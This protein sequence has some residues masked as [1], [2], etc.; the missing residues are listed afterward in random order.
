MPRLK[1]GGGAGRAHTGGPVWNMKTDPDCCPVAR[2]AAEHV[3]AFYEELDRRLDALLSVHPG[4]SCRECG[5]CCIFLPGVPVLYATVL[6]HAYLAP[7]L[8][9]PRAGL[10]EGACPCL[11]LDTR[12]CTARGR[13]PVVCRMHFCDDV[14]VERAAREAA[15]DLSEWAYAELHRISDA[16]GFAWECASVTDRPSGR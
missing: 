3:R 14:L 13:R 5:T 9:P 11:D 6:E 15:R 10:P 7:E 2:D 1:G 8:P 4:A 12:L 16:N